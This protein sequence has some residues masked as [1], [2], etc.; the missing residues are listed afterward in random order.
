MVL[1]KVHGLPNRKTAAIGGRGAGNLWVRGH[2][3]TQAERRRPPLRR[4]APPQ[5]ATF[6]P[7]SRL[8][9][10]TRRHAAVCGLPKI[11][12]DLI[13]V[14][15]PHDFERRRPALACMR[16]PC[17]LCCKRARP[18]RFVFRHQKHSQRVSAPAWGRGN[19]ACKLDRGG[20]RRHASADLM[21]R[22]SPLPPKR[23]PSPLLRL[24][25]VCGSQRI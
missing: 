19:L 23:E 21:A 13:L 3:G 1:F 2:P 15:R 16:A 18:A 22:Q 4:R 6:V 20:G 7:D 12:R 24:R 17:P 5:N 14:R 25:P 10:G 11:A 9:T 8:A